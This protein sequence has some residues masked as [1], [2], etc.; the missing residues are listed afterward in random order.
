MPPQ[1]RPSLCLFCAFASEHVTRPLR[2]RPL[3]Q[4][5]YRSTN[6][7]GSELEEPKALD[8]LKI[9]EETFERAWRRFEQDTRQNLRKKGDVLSSANKGKNSLDALLRYN[10]YAQICNAKFTQAELENQRELADLRYPGEWYPGARSVGRTIHLHVGPTNSGK[11]YHAL[12]RLEEAESGVYLGPLRLL[13]HEVYSRLNAKGKPCALVTGEEKRIPDVDYAMT[14][15]TVEM[16]PLNAKL[17]V[18]V[19]DEIQMINH[20]ERGWA[21]TAALLGLQ[22]KEVHVCG[23]ERAVPIVRELC[24]LLGDKVEVHRYSRLTPLE[25]ADKSLNGNLNKL[26]KGDCIVSFSVLGIH[27]LRKEIEK[28]TGR[29]VAIVYGSLPPETRAQ[30]AKLFNDPDNDY[31]FLVASDAIG[32]GL[33]LSVKRI[34]FEAMS[35][36]NGQKLMPLNISD[37]KQIGG[38]AGRYRT[39]HQAISEGSSKDAPEATNNSGNGL[40]DSNS[41]TAVQPSKPKSSTVGYVTTLEAFDYPA[42]K[43]KMSKDPPMIL[44]AGI[45]PPAIIIER[46]AN[47]FPPGTPFSYILLRLHEIAD[48][49]PRFHQCDLRDITSIADAIQTVQNLSVIDRLTLCSAPANMRNPNEQKFIH[50]LAECIAEGRSGHLLDLPYLPLE[51]LDQSPSGEREYLRNLEQMH[52]MLVLYLWL[53]YRFPN[54]FTTRSL[55]DYTKK[56]VENSIES[57]LQDFSFTPA[58]IKAAKRKK[59]MEELMKRGKGDPNT[60]PEPAK[61][62]SQKDPPKISN[63][64]YPPKLKSKKNISALSQHGTPPSPLPVVPTLKLKLRLPLLG[65]EPRTLS[66]A[67]CS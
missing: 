16:A 24:A 55:A 56:L 5:A 33:N 57:C 37:V 4:V 7:S 35:K 11:T 38:R 26:E 32:M 34:I 62:D 6:S 41:P 20:I 39:A 58:A 45:F 46:F 65:L 52:K 3:A 47:Y 67:F 12:K 9:D 59:K 19:I 42:L 53:S 2:L 61:R 49:H 10:F 15:C 14:S 66:V 50:A 60:E 28:K 31:D 18:A 51:L 1:T 30:Q 27:A 13:A 25:V 43:S 64:T 17:D 22:A 40:D 54:V 44:T 21:W 8:S 36:S 63:R 23:E 29:K 48:M